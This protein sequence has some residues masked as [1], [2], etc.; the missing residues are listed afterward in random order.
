MW[1]VL[2]RLKIPFAIGC[3]LGCF[4]QASGMTGINFYSNW[5]F[6]DSTGSASTAT[7]YTMISNVVYLIAAYNSAYF[8]EKH[9]RR[10]LLIMGQIILIVS[11][12]GMV[13]A[14]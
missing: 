7:L 6:F 3:L 12:V 4:Q 13:V 8:I 9:G 11:L 2:T 14:T 1:D 10:S 5:I